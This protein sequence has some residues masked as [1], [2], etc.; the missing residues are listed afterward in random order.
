MKTHKLIL[1]LLAV[2]IST[3]GWVIPTQDVQAIDPVEPEKV[4]L[5]LTS[6]DIRV[7]QDDNVDPMNYVVSGTF[8]SIDYSIIDT[9]EVGPQLVVYVA[10]KG[11]E[12]IKLSKIVRVVDIYGPVIE[13]DDEQVLSF[14]SEFVIESDYVAIDEVDGEVEVVL[15]GDV[16]RSTPGEYAVQVQA[17][18]SSDNTTTKDIT[19]IISEDPEVVARRER[20]AEYSVLVVDAQNLINTLLEDTSVSE[21]ED[22][23]YRVY[24]AK[25]LDSDYQ[26]ELTNLYS[27][28]NAKLDRVEDYYYVPP[29]P[30]ASTTSSTYDPNPVYNSYSPGWCTWWVATQRYVPHG[31]GDAINWLGRAQG[32]GMATGSTPTVGSIMTWPG[33]NHVA[34]VEAVHGDGT[35]TISEMGIGWQAWG[36]QRRTMST[37]G[38]MFIY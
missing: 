9:S 7:K 18:D 35:V 34:Y 29:A 1:L 31:W 33:Q 32:A 23:L 19:V 28:L 27:E 8:D 15:V 6:A 37:S 20:N 38:A 17:T 22:M 11:Q 14:E 24:D 30:V 3:G 12:T 5:V 13:G 2:M 26:V 21:V 4:E 36:F 16:D 10:T 25:D